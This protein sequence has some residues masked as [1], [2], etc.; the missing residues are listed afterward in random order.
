MTLPRAAATASPMHRSARWFMY[1]AF[2]AAK[3]GHLGKGNRVRI[4]LCVV[5]AI[6]SR[7]RAPGCDCTASA[8]AMCTTHGYT[9]HK[10]IR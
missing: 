3:Y 6:R 9:G 5:G 10:E 2:V 1:R 7:Y 4:P 8:I